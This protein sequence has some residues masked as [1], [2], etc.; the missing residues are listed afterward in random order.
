[1]SRNICVWLDETAPAVQDEMRA[2][3]GAA[4]ARKLVHLIEQP[5]TT[6]QEII[7][8]PCRLLA[9]ETVGPAPR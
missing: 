4:A 9:G 2:R 5:R 1:M 6:F 7:P 8:I 3:I